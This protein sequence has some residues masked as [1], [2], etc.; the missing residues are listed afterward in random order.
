MGITHARTAGNH[1]GLIAMVVAGIFGLTGVGFIGYA[2]THQEHAPQPPLSEGVPTSPTGIAT[3][4]PTSTAPTT[5]APTVDSAG[6]PIPQEIPIAGA[7]GP[8]PGVNQGKP[9]QV[10]G[11]IM[12]RSEPV[13]LS[14]PAI[15]VHSTLLHLGQTAQGSLQVPPPGPN[16]NKAAWYRLSPTPGELGPAILVGHIDSAKEGPSV[17]FRLGAMK[18][19]DTVRVSRKDG[20]VAVF[21]VDSVL[22]FSKQ[23][24]PRELVYGNTDHAA[25]RIITCGGAFDRDSGSY[26]DNTIV[27][28]S[29]VS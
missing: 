16:Y 26:L 21:S 13:S 7:T 23:K 25:L 17:F 2:I 5:V 10:A 3:T 12:S 22:R 6:A 9:A 20:S 15:N 14:I 1:L 18:K 8:A 24:F 28:A 19:H 27:L 29:L 4:A 11:R